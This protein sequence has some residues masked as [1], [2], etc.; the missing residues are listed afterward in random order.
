MTPID[1]VKSE[2]HCHLLE[3]VSLGSVS[4]A[5]EAVAVCSSQAGP[6]LVS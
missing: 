3:P 6:M 1:P 2:N 5:P 4:F